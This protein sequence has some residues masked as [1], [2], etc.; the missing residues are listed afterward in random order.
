MCFLLGKLSLKQTPLNL[1]LQMKYLVI[2]VLIN[3]C[4][5]N[6][7]CLQDPYYYIVFLLS[8]I[9]FLPSWLLFQLMKIINLVMT[10]AICHLVSSLCFTN[11]FSKYISYRWRSHRWYQ[12]STH[13]YLKATRKQLFFPFHV[14]L[15]LFHKL[16]ARL[17][18]H[19]KAWSYKKK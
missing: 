6:K 18:S 11:S 2:L 7:T 15:F 17:N 3:C 8:W 10:R 13:R 1:G 12:W 14:F 19:Y 9:H 5:R 4:G 16:H